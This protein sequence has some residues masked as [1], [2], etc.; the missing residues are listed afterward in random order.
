LTGASRSWR[1][2]RNVGLNYLTL[3]W[4]LALLLLGVLFRAAR[5]HLKEPPERARRET[6]SGWFDFSDLGNPLLRAR[7]SLPGFVLICD[8]VVLVLLLGLHQGNGILYYHQFVTPFLL[9]LVCLHVDVAW[10][11][12]W[13]AV[14][15]IVANVCWLSVKT[16]RLP[17]DYAT[18]WRALDQQVASHTNVFNAPHLAHILVKQNRPVYDTGQTE[19]Y[20]LATRKNFMAIAAAYEQK[21]K[22]YR[23][24]MTEDIRQQK[25]DLIAISPGISFLLPLRELRNHYLLEDTLAAPMA[26][27]AYPM[28]TFPVD[29]WIPKKSGPG[30]SPLQVERSTVSPRP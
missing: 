20:P 15:L 14:L 10:N 2:L 9:W 13:P 21:G 18:Q 19:C 8:V 5:R 30:T 27:D 16:P 11:R 1:H 26:F 7:L 6:A 4:G 12:P 29:I 25:F 17:G 3:N 28:D 22:A 24:K 23:E